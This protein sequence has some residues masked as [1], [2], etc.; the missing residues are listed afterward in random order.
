MAAL[1]NAT[2]FN[3]SDIFVNA[4]IFAVYYAAIIKKK[5]ERAKKKVIP[6]INYRRQIEII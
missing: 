2:N 3:V 5:P 4:I 1:I 6:K